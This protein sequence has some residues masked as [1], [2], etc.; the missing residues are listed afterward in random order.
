[1]TKVIQISTV[2][3]ALVYLTTSIVGFFAFGS[4]APELFVDG[5]PRSGMNL[6]FGIGIITLTINSFTGLP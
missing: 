3:T 2:F 4:R 5:W 6:F 1:M